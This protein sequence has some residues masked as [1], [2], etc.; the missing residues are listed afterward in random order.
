MAQ[1]KTLSRC[2]IQIESRPFWLPQ[3]NRDLPI[4]KEILSL[5]FRKERILTA[6]SMGIGFL[7]GFLVLV[8]KFLKI[9]QNE[10]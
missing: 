7:S 3:H 10:S 4:R 6:V 1:K 8:D 5:F 9:V 2:E